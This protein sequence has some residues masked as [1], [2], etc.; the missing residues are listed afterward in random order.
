MMGSNVHSCYTTPSDQVE[1]AVIMSLEWE[2][3][4]HYKGYTYS[5]PMGFVWNPSN[6]VVVT[7]DH[8]L[9]RGRQTALSF[10]TD[11]HQHV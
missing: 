6:L 3:M 2:G 10:V 5:Q 11:C 7:N 1:H 9:T 8:V 4:I